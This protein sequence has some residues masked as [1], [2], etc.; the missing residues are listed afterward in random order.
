MLQLYYSKKF[1]KGLKKIKNNQQLLENLNTVLDLLINDNNLPDRYKEHRLK[2]D[3]KKFW[4]CHISPDL[5]LIYVKEQTAIRLIALDNHSN[6]KF[7]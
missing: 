6:L 5:L 7:S 3:L 1:R 2:G 4:E